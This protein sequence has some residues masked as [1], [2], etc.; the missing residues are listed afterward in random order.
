MLPLLR[1]RSAFRRLWL[2]HTVSRDGDAF[3]TVVPLVLVF[4]L[5]RSGIGVAGTVAFEVLPVV[6][7]G[8]IAGL[9]TD[10]SHG[11]T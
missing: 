2:A 3:N 5:T 11:V 9:V 6:L 7:L 10:R 4:D 1:R 8:P